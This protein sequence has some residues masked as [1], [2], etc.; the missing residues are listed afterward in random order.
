LPDIV[1]A[2]WFAVMAAAA[3]L[4]LCGLAYA[5]ALIRA[6]VPTGGLERM[7]I[8]PSGV[9]ERAAAIAARIRAHVHDRLTASEATLAPPAA[10]EPMRPPA[11]VHQLPYLI[12]GEAAA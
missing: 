7:P 9:P 5:A 1:E 4:F 10:G 2:L 6:L 12:P 8:P 11:A 3:S